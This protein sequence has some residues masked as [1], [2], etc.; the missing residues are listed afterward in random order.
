MIQD[1]RAGYPPAGFT[2]PDH[3]T[4]P[5][6]TRALINQFAKI[7]FGLCICLLVFVLALVIAPTLA[8]ATQVSPSTAQPPG[9][10]LPNIKREPDPAG[11]YFHA[12]SGGTAFQAPLLKSEVSIA[13][14]GMVQRVRVRQHFEN[15]TDVWLQ[16]TYVF[17]LPEGAAVDHLVMELKDR[18]VEGEIMEKAEAQKAFD[19]AA[20]QGKRASLLSGERPNVFTSAVTNI[21]PGDKILVEIEYQDQVGYDDGLFSLRFPMVVAPRYTPPRPDLVA[22]RSSPSPQPASTTRGLDD[23]AERD[24]FGPVADPADFPPEHLQ[25]PLVL[26][27]SLNAGMPLAKIRSTSH[28]IVVESDDMGE[29]ASED[30]NLHNIMLSAGTVSADRDFVLEWRP[31]EGHD[32]KAA[33][34]AEEIAGDSYLMVM[35]LPPSQSTQSPATGEDA[36][37]SQSPRIA[38][39]MIV[40]IDTSGSMFG[41]SID[42][43]K[44]A[45]L[46]AL[47][48]LGPDDR[49]NIVRFS[50]ESSSLFP[51][52]QLANREN[53]TAAWYYVKALVAEGGTHMR[54]ALNRA[55]SHRTDPGRLRQ[56]IFM[57]DGAVSNETELFRQTVAQLGESRL[58]TIGIGSAPN[59]YFMRKAAQAGR[60]TF[61]YIS[62]VSQVSRTLDQLF[63]KLDAPA[64]THVSTQWPAS[65]G[66]VAEVFPSPVPDLY[67]GE[68]VIFTTRLA[69]T[70][71]ANLQGQVTLTGWHGDQPWEQRLQLEKEQP[72]SGI[73]ALWARAKLAQI[74]DGL[75]EGRVADRVRAEALQVALTHR[76]VSRYTSLVAI[77]HQVVRPET[78]ETQAAEVPRALP[79]GWSYGKIFGGDKQKIEMLQ[80][81][82]KLLQKTS[83]GNPIALPQ[84]STPARMMLFSGFLALALGI[85]LFTLFRRG[86]AYGQT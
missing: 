18:R 12:G 62:D 85:V 50:D 75:M 73:A 3:R 83:A 33:I 57:T 72:S 71:L 14:N 43:A 51:Q 59:S 67:H 23:G 66:A 58:F 35:L 13:V 21:P 30:R 55:L 48:R 32:P 77:D 69:N 6:G 79:E 68:P 84:G 53:L 11:L 28:D 36:F 45:L 44:E 19:D 63:A 15:P 86:Q 20:R 10:G 9:S 70:K 78:A 7:S 54:P 8:K 49:F 41:P 46:Q 1:M 42:Q 22:G 4:F 76:L 81:P 5:P 47:Q 34:F 74:E 2:G 60:G 40:I 25:N 80:L 64:L 38:R 24:L 31:V 16:G 37:S 39:D 26:Q 56:V 29:Q 61:T 52:A 82:E 27:V 65:L 17:P